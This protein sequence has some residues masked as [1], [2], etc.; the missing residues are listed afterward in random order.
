METKHRE[1]APRFN[2][3]FIPFAREAASA[4]MG[5]EANAAYAQHLA[6][7]RLPLRSKTWNNTCLF[8]QMFPVRLRDYSLA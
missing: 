4:A 6:E 1:H 7:G 8:W 2:A 5:E 3:I